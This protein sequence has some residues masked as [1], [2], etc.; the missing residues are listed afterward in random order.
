M[1]LLGIL[2]NDR[3]F[4][5]DKDK[6]FVRNLNQC[7]STFENYDLIKNRDISIGNGKTQGKG[8]FNFRYGPVSSGVGEAGIFNLYTYGERILSVEVDPIYK[9]RNIEAQMVG[10]TPFEALK[11]AESVCGNFSFSHSLAFTTALENQT[12]IELNKTV[13]RLRIIGLELERTYNHIHQIARLAKG[14]SQTVL[15]SHLEWIFEELLRTNKLLFGNRFLK[16]TNFLGSTTINLH[17]L[18]KVKNRITQLKEK[19]EELYEHALQS[20]NFIDRLYGV[21]RL[22]RK[23]AL[24]IGLTGPS[25]RACGINEDLRQLN[26]LY[27]NLKIA[28]RSEGDALARME[29]RAEEFINSCEIIL[30]QIEKIDNE[31]Q[32]EEIP[33]NDGDYLGYSCS[34]TGIIA[35]YLEI[36]KGLIDYVYIST[37]SVFGFRAFAEAIT[38]YIFT[39]FSFI[40]DSFGINFADC[41]R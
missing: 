41:A 34:P 17:N 40:F 35:Y 31:P 28:T 25:L 30:S 3:L 37:P 23:K 13:Q 14:A 36:R 22:E 2:K 24:N 12:G 39:D 1:R 4:V 6:L 33:I 15:T 29:V 20:Y 5:Q 8:V 21:G 27:E 11:L 32:K 7:S 18:E 10:K 16:H 26:R 19:F 9:K 38:G